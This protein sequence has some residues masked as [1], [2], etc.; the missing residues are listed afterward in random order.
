MK[1]RILVA[2]ALCIGAVVLLKP[3]DAKAD[4]MKETFANIGD[5]QNT[6]AQAKADLANAQ[7]KQSDLWNKYNWVKNNGGSD[8]D[9]Q[10]AYDEYNNQCNIVHWYQDQVNLAA[11]YI[12]QCST[13][14]ILGNA[15]T[16]KLYELHGDD[17]LREV[18]DQMKGANDAANAALAQYNLV[19]SQIAQYQAQVAACPEFQ[20]QINQLTAMLPGLQADY[21]AKKAYADQKTAQYNLYVQQLQQKGYLVNLVNNATATGVNVNTYTSNP[22]KNYNSG[23]FVP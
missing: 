9:V 17:S 15:Q 16:A 14:Q 2:V 11:N 12:N 19:V 5:A 10:K 18:Q 20:V 8:Y 1:K 3:V 7:A 21:A 4:I 22:Q 13:S 23:D 6:L